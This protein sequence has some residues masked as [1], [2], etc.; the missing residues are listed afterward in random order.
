MARALRI[1]MAAAES[2]PFAKTG[3]LADV[4]GSLPQSLRHLT[5]ALRLDVRVALPRYRAMEAPARDL[6][7]LRVPFDGINQLAVAQQAERAAPA[8]TPTYFIDAP[9]YFD[10]PQLYGYPDDILRFGFFCRAILE[11]LPLLDWQPDIIH[12]HDWHA[13]LLPV[14]ARTA[15]APGTPQGRVKTIYSIHNMVYQGCADTSF[16]PRLG[17]DWSLY[18]LHQLEFYGQIN[19]MKGG[20][21]FSDALTTVSPTYAR[22]I[23]Q[24]EYGA[25]LDGVL[26]ERRDDLRGIIN[27]LDYALWNPRDDPYL[28]HHFGPHDLAGKRECK[29]D[30]LRRVGLPASDAQ[31]PLIG[32]VSRLSSQK[33]CDLLADAL[34]PL[35][36]LGCR[37]VVLGA[38]DAYYTRL[39]QILGHRSP[40]V[41]FALNSYD[42][43]LAHQIYAGSDLF[44]MPSRY[45]PCGLSQMIS[46]AYGTIPVVRETG[47]LADTV[48]EFDGKN[49]N[50]FV[51]RPYRAEA[52]LEA[53]ARALRCYRSPAWKTLMEN[54]FACDFSWD[55]SA[56]EYSRLYQSVREK[57]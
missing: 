42:E 1:L 23:Q 28:E 33:G 24:P 35:L 13:G 30:L 54:A 36:A 37:L 56:R 48:R 7:V 22:E 53:V 44:L 31:K 14:Y 45:E 51:F 38:G 46:L 10:R 18:N 8:A 16:L 5:E 11:M 25:K 9:Q 21:V 40:E 41:V 20:L 47:G 34:A 17:L 6:G 19:P 2:V 50:G 57:K 3:G 27:G 49:G 39:F 55:N 15:F 32:M 12:C 52:L 26:R 4:I 29:L 43:A